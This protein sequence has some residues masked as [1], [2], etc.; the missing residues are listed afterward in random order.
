MLLA[1]LIGVIFALTAMLAS[2]CVA[3]GV[4]AG[5]HKIMAAMVVQAQRRERHLTL[6]LRSWQTK[7]LEQGGLG[8][9]YRHNTPAPPPEPSKPGR[10]V[11]A[12][13]QAIADQK[14][15]DA[16]GLPHVSE[17][18]SSVPPAIQEPF[19]RDLGSVIPTRGE[20]NHVHQT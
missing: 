18:P 8:R 7:T 17:V 15:A 11:V 10:R 9:L 3:V 5:Q 12:A 1:L 2:A 19:L 20:N 4:L 16:Q 14:K 13:S 6:D